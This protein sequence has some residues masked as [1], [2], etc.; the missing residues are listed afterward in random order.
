MITDCGNANHPDG[1]WH[2]A[3]PL[4]GSW[5]WTKRWR[6]RRNIRS[7][8]CGC[9]VRGVVQERDAPVDWEAIVRQRERELKRVGEERHQANAAIRELAQAIRL[10]RE[11]VGP[12]KL[13][14]LDGWSWYD[15]LKRHAPEY[16]AEPPT[17]V[18]DLTRLEDQ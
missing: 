7:H 10:T 14:A 3:T 18:P 2:Q 16:L 15:A 12:E 5:Q 4:P 13:P 8:G 6:Y 11:Y 1:P 17:A 9:D